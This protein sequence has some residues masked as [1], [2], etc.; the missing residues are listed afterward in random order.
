MLPIVQNENWSSLRAN[1][2]PKVMQRDCPRSRT[3]HRPWIKLCF[4]QNGHRVQV[5]DPVAWKDAASQAWAALGR[6]R[7][8]LVR[9][10]GTQ[11]NPGDSQAEPS[12]HINGSCTAVL[13]NFPQKI[14]QKSA[15]LKPILLAALHSL[16]S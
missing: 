10:E 15:W 16:C 5:V 2:L 1:L 12:S 4:E 9:G 7:E 3:E 14:E 11:E 6:V 8:G 13:E